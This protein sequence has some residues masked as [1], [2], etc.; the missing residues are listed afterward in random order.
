MGNV[1]DARAILAALV[2][3]GFDAFPYSGR[4][5]YGKN[6]VGVRLDK[7]QSAYHV[8]A[9]LGAKFGADATNLKPAE[10]SLGL[11][12]VLYFP[13]VLWS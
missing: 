8:G 12:T 6:C 2:R 7:T 3:A 9:A 11:G 4:G 10:E 5:M 13:E 1:M